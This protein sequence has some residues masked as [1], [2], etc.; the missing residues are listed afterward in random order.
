MA[1]PKHGTVRRY[2]AGCRCD[3]C[4]AANT[5]AKRRERERKAEREGRSVKR[6]QASKRVPTS[7]DVPTGSGAGDPTDREIEREFERIAR[8]S[9]AGPIEREVWALLGEMDKPAE[10]LTREV[11]LRAA[12]IM[13]NPGSAALFKAGADVMRSFI[14]DHLATKPGGDGKSG[15]L[16][17]FLGS[18]G[19]SRGRRNGPAVDD[20]AQSG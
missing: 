15:A 10:R 20:A 11:V 7:R 8:L 3:E 9:D 2:R 13:D 4:K 12:Q 17:E 16:A 18:I 19:S 1:L 6:P 14:A 5:A